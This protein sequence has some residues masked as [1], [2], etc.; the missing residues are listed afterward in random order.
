MSDSGFTQF[1]DPSRSVQ[2]T[3]SGPRA[4]SPDQEIVRLIGVAN[5]LR[6]IAKAERLRGEI[7]RQNDDDSVRI[8]TERGNID[9]RPQEGRQ[10]QSGQTV[11]IDIPP[12]NPPQEAVL[13]VRNEAQTQTPTPQ[14]QP[15]AKITNQPQ[16]PPPI[17]IQASTT[18]LS[19]LSQNTAI[20]Q[21]VQNSNTITQPAPTITANQPLEPGLLARL[22]PIQNFNPAA[23]PQTAPAPLGQI[24]TAEAFFQTSLIGTEAQSQNLQTL[25]QIPN[26]A[27]TPTQ[28]FLDTPLLPE[29]AAQLAQADTAFPGAALLQQGT[30]DATLKAQAQPGSTSTLFFDNTQNLAQ[31]PQDTFFTPRVFDIR[32][33]A[34]EAASVQVQDGD[35][36]PP[37]SARENLIL[38]N[39]PQTLRA[40]IIGKTPDGFPV[41]SIPAVTGNTSSSSAFILPAKADDVHTGQ[42]LQVSASGTSQII[43]GAPVVLPT[44]PL[45]FTTPG[46]WQTMEE[47]YRTLTQHAPA[48]AVTMSTSTPNAQ[49]S[50]AQITA[51]AMFFIAALKG[52]DLS[53]WLGERANNILRDAGKGN[54]LT[55]LGQEG[56]TMARM[57]DGSPGEWRALSLPF[58][59]Q[60]EIEKVVLS[61]KQDRDDS[62]DLDDNTKKGTRFI[63]DLSLSQMGKVQLDG[64]LKGET[65]NLVVRTESPV[66]APMQATM[67]RAYRGA[68]ESTEI[69]G[70]LSFTAKPDSWVMISAKPDTMAVST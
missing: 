3:Q 15:Q 35:S 62:D 57:S 18:S 47:I 5:E 37:P 68:L 65:L 50:P 56:A 42:R 32:L 13:I 70:D 38:D 59:A 23:F 1:P 52:G 2:N 40:D 17:Q 31:L 7:I 41:L 36:L 14:S 54:L 22:I 12:G 20:P 33:A 58:F 48:Q 34:I 10:F 45:V 66:S 24:L 46:N 49:G 19:A 28:S 4:K 25:L 63:F 61:Y 30:P 6:A 21:D 53:S 16:Q 8:R 67:R 39:S 26:A 27:P 51:A 60:G 44:L 55:R 9:V 29:R 64:F 11:T 43:S 69:S